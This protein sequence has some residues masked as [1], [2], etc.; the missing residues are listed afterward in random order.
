MKKVEV[1]NEDEVKVLNES[2]VKKKMELH[3]MRNQ[4]RPSRHL[5]NWRWV[6][7]RESEVGTKKLGRWHLSKI[8]TEGKGLASRECPRSCCPALSLSMWRRWERVERSRGLAPWR[9]KKYLV[10][11]LSAPLSVAFLPPL[12]SVLFNH[13]ARLFPFLSFLKITARGS[14]LMYHHV[15]ESLNFLIWQ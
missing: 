6:L 15:L 1:W 11:R 4:T 14:D 12:N 8:M 7:S 2:V 9:A 3:K 10:V 5:H 13:W